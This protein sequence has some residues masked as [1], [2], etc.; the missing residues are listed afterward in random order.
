MSK[1]IWDAIG[2]RF[3]ETGISHGVLYPLNAALNTYPL[4]YVWN[5]LTGVTETPAGADL[6][7]LWADDI[8]YASIRAADTFGA[9]IE[10]YTYPEKFAECDGSAALVAGIYIGQQSRKTFGFA[11]RTV[12]GNDAEGLDGAAGYKLHLIYG[13][14]AAPSE[15]AFATIN[16][17]PDAITFSWELSTTPVPVTGHKPTALL[18]IE[19]TKVDPTK[20]A[21]LEDILYGTASLAPRLPLPN[22]V[23]TLMTGTAV[24]P[25][26][27]TFVAAT[28]V[29]TIPALTG[30]IYLV[31]GV[32]TV[33][34]PMVAMVG[35]VSAVVTADP[36]ATYYFA[37]GT[38]DAW[39]FVST[40]P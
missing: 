20:L 32:V 16:D 18:T 21:A 6:T 31:N 1:L 19:S 7:D 5:G 14:S 26:V 8:K 11:Y 28:G 2:E 10:A 34:G 27:P 15:K 9:T 23:A 29:L 39:T 37:A 22:E 36:A 13:A 30:V 25:T 24:I 40:K 4:G 35:G 17:S 3:F 33:A 12:I 38:N